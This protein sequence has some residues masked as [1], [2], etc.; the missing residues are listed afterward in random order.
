MCQPISLSKKVIPRAKPVMSKHSVGT[1]HGRI[2]RLP[3]I[4]AWVLAPVSIQAAATQVVN[5]VFDSQSV[6]DL[7]EWDEP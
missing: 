2:S 1:G 4:A 6:V 5:R 3:L 7:H